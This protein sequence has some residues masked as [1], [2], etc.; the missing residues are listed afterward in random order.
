M[1]FDRL[2]SLILRRFPKKGDEWAVFPIFDG[3]CLDT[4]N[5]LVNSGCVQRKA[6]VR[7]TCEGETRLGY[8]LL[9]GDWRAVVRAHEGTALGLDPAEFK[10]TLVRAT[11]LGASLRPKLFNAD[12]LV[13][14]FG[15]I[16]YIKNIYTAGS[17]RLF[18]DQALLEQANP[19][20]FPIVEPQFHDA[21][22]YNF[23]T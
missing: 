23:D 17:I 6:K 20:P 18:Y 8:A 3:S 4:L 10:G 14:Q 7:W 5:L 22:A 9:T 2:D 12:S 16:E 19:H 21:A 1:T 11:P 13:A 15:A